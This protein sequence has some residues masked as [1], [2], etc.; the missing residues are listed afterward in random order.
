MQ[1]AILIVERYLPSGTVQMYSLWNGRKILRVKDISSLTWHF[2]PAILPP[3]TA[4]IK[5]TEVNLALNVDIM[6]RV[7][8][9]LH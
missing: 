5:D 4:Q 6:H 8:V 2:V 3:F 7:D 9:G 1:K